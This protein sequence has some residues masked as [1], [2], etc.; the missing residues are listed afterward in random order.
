[1]FKIGDRKDDSSTSIYDNGGKVVD[2]LHEG[3]ELF[4]M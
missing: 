1:M 3:G 2:V 4:W